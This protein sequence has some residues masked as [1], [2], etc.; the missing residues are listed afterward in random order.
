MYWTATPNFNPKFLSSK[1]DRSNIRNKSNC[2]YICI[3]LKLLCS[4]L[5]MRTQWTPK[6]NIIILY[7]DDK[8]CTHREWSEEFKISSAGRP[9]WN[10][11][12]EVRYCQFWEWVRVNLERSD[13]SSLRV[14]ARV[15]PA[16]TGKPTNQSAAGKHDH[17][18]A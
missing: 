15:F 8:I 7:R 13:W 2:T 1:S 6:L 3:L 14:R 16:V 5:A 18:W 10:W 4:V 9:I 11:E 12:T 17:I